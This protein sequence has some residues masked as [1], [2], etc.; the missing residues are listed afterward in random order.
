MR[1]LTYVPDAVKITS[2]CPP[3][4]KNDMPTSNNKHNEIKCLLN[5]WVK[6][7]GVVMTVNR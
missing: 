5:I 7:F 4:H 2:P 3:F 1:P 6:L